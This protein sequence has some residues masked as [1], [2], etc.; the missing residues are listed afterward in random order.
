M[1]EK[2][3]SRDW[4]WDGAYREAEGEEGLRRSRRIVDGGV[5]WA[6]AVV[7]EYRTGRAVKIRRDEDA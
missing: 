4:D 7:E 5:C 3:V 2:A 1:T 6:G